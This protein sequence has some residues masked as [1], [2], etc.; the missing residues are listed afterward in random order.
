LGFIVFFIQ[1][2]ATD[3]DKATFEEIY[4]QLRLQPKDRIRLQDIPINSALQANTNKVGKYVWVDI[5]TGY[6]KDKASIKEDL[7]ALANMNNRFDD[8]TKLRLGKGATLNGAINDA[9]I[10]TNGVPQ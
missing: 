4:H 2:A 9:G 10:V 1:E 8:K 6:Y 7:Q 3:R 5:G